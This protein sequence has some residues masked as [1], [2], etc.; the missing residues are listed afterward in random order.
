MAEDLILCIELIDYPSSYSSLY[1]ED[2]YTVIEDVLK[3]N[4]SED[5]DVVQCGRSGKPK[6]YNVGVKSRSIWVQHQIDDFLEQKFS[7]ATGKTVLLQRAYQRF[8]DVTVKHIPP[9]WGK[10]QVERI[11]SF[12]GFIISITKETLKVNVRRGVL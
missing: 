6:R 10:E 1:I 9:H 7:I 11:F 5:V 12:Y 8:D 3:L 2:I 4:P